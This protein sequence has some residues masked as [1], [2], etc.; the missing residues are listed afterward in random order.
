MVAATGGDVIHFKDA[1][2]F[3]SWIGLTPKFVGQQQKT[4][5]HLLRRAA[6]SRPV[7]QSAATSNEETPTHR[8]RH[9][10]LTALSLH[11]S[12]LAPRLRRLTSPCPSA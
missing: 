11:P 8:F 9:R 6:R 7:R 4:R 1:R 2:H 3:A 12:P 10:R 5:P